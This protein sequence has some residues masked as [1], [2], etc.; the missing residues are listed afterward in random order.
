MNENKNMST[1]PQKDFEFSQE[2]I[3]KLTDY[4]SERVVGQTGLRNSLIT[5]IVADGHILIESV[6][7][8]AKTTAAKAISDALDGKFSRIQCTP[9]LLPSDIIGTQIYHQ[10]TGK[11]ETIFGPVFANFVLLDEVNRSSAKTQSAMLEAMQERQVTIGGVTYHMPRDI[12]IVIA[13]QNPIEQEGTY[14]LSEAQTDRFMI[15]EKITYPTTEEEI[16]IMNKIE[17]GSINTVKPAVLTLEDVDKVQD[18]AEMVY[19]DP[20][21]KKYI[22]DIVTA[23]R[24]PATHIDKKFAQYIR[25]GASPRATINFLKIAKASALIHGRTF[26]IPEDVKGMAHQILRHRIGLNY[27]AVADNVSV[28]T[29]ID[30]IVNSVQTP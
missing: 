30:K 14:P 10:E 22:A 4:F 18:I 7:G 21:V 17:D 6:P 8:L 11:F 20:S 9:D 3:R 15:K 29:V 16:L 12:F 19:V 1:V 27:A 13:T 28:E 2:V 23:T 24:E 5:S 25:I 26:A